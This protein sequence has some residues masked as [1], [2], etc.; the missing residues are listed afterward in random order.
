MRVFLHPP[1]HSPTTT[2]ASPYIG[3][4]KP[5]QDQ[6]TPLSLMSDKAILCC[7]Y[8]WSHGF[9]PVH[10]LVG[11]LVPG[12]TGWSGQPTEIVLPMGFQSLSTSLVFL[13]A[14]QPGSPNSV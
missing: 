6:R 4:I 8:I 14:P 10:S 13:S 5:L 9:L 3:S 7:I 1:T 12:S 2:P 11:V